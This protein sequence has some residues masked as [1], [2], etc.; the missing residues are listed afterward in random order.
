VARWSEA[1]GCVG[2]LVYTD[3]RLVDPWLVAQEILVSTRTLAPLVATQPVYMHPYSVAKMIATLGYLYGRRLCLNMVAGGFKNDLL[4][5]GDETPHDLRYARLEEYTAIVLGL[6]RGAA[7]VSLAGIFN[8]ART[9]TLPPRRQPELLPG[10]YLSGSSEAGRAA[11]AASGAIA[12]EYPQPGGSYA[13]APAGAGAARGMRIGIIT[14]PDDASAWRLARE[15]FPEDR[16]GQNAHKVAMK[17]SDSAWHADLAGRGEGSE[18][19][20]SPYWLGPF[21]NYQTFCPYLVGSQERVAAEIATYMRAG[22]RTFIL[23]IPRR[24]EDVEP[25]PALFRRAEELAG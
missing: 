7:P 18:E 1:A 13:A 6:L 14:A 22:F 15:R 8:K 3:N 11:A 25:L 23:D 2:I 4:N 19:Q 12:V 9:L 5:L 20:E 21:Q 24:P 17:V 16:R 10:L